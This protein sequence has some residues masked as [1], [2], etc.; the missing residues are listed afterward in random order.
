MQAVCFLE[1]GKAFV[2][3]KPWDPRDESKWVTEL[4]LLPTEAQQYIAKFVAGA[5]AVE[6]AETAGEAAALPGGAAAPAVRA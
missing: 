5:A 4:H 2:P 6:A 3:A 1:A